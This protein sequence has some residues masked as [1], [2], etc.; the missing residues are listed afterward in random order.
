MKYI[1]FQ[2]ALYIHGRYQLY[3]IEI[4]TKKNKRITKEIK[5]YIWALFLFKKV[6]KSGHFSK[7]NPF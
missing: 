3:C 4:I 6:N 2:N 7:I 5:Q 1:D